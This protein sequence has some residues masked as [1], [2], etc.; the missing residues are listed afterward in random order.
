MPT[1]TPFL[2]PLLACPD[3]GAADAER[4]LS[5]PTVHSSTTRA[6]SMKAAKRRDDRTQFEN[7]K[8]RLEYEANH[9]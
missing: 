7:M 8:A 1:M 4:L 2:A 9:D 3:C 6:R 5:L